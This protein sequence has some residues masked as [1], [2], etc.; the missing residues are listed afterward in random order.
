MMTGEA[1]DTRTIEATETAIARSRTGTGTE[2][3]QIGGTPGTAGATR[4]TAI[5]STRGSRR[6][7]DQML[8]EG[9]LGDPTMI[10]TTAQQAGV[11]QTDMDRATTSA[12]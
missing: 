2:A 7:I 5:A 8:L 10:E 11:D 3:I 9:T 12:L 4:T 1:L 6:A